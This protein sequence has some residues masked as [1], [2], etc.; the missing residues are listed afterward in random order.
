MGKSNLQVSF[1][2]G[3]FVSDKNIWN[4]LSLSFT[5]L[6]ASW[7]QALKPANLHQD[8]KQFNCQ[9]PRSRF[10]QMTSQIFDKLCETKYSFKGLDNFASPRG[11]IIVFR[12]KMSKKWF[13]IF[14]ILQNVYWHGSGIVRWLPLNLYYSTMIAIH[15]ILVIPLHRDQTIIVIVIYFIL[16]TK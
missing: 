3:L 8:R 9:T 14:K 1:S 7:V 13:F 6:G 15:F 11:K 12:S 5:Y 10:L 2:L 16:L 4:P